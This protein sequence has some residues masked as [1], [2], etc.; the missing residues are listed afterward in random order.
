MWNTSS[1][2]IP[3]AGSVTKDLIAGEDAVQGLFSSANICTRG[4]APSLWDLQENLEQF[5]LTGGCLKDFW[6]QPSKKQRLF[7]L[8]L[9]PFVGSKKGSGAD[10]HS[11]AGAAVGSGTPCCSKSLG[12]SPQAGR[13]EP[14]G[15]APHRANNTL[16]RGQSPKQIPP[17]NS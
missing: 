11:T 7:I 15:L 12:M 14:S 8:T 10:P 1:S 2:V 6:D 16:R 5:G 13:A 3:E 9:I 17:G 4:C